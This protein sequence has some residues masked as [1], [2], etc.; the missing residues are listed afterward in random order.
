MAYTYSIHV[1]IILIYQSINR[2]AIT[3]YLI[4]Y[5]C[6]YHH[7]FIITVNIYA[8]IIMYY[9]DHHLFLYNIHHTIHHIKLFSLSFY[10]RHLSSLVI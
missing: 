5:S 8:Y 4:N 7:H 2:Y 6:Y 9:I 1:Y 10:T 3:I